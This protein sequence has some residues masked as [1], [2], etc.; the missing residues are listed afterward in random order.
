M[1]VI[2]RYGETVQ[3]LLTEIFESEVEAIERAARLATTSIASGGVLHVFGTGHS[4]MI[5][6]EA[7]GRAGGLAAVNAIVDIALTPFNHGRDGKLER[8]AGYAEVLLETEDLRPGEVVVVVSNSGINAVPIDFAVG[9][10]ARGL[11]VVAITSMGHSRSS[12]SRHPSGQKLYEVAEIVID[13]HVV[14]G[15]AALTLDGIG[16]IGPTSTVAGAVIIN[17]LTARVAEL[18]LEAGEISPVLISQN[19]PGMEDRNRVQI[20][21]YRDRTRLP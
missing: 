20:E 4:H 16:K 8:L 17:A 14:L 21:R 1:T 9:C 5:A 7:F 3:Q 6:F 19:L 12:P 15:D 18:L 11:H 13:T 2:E 10:R